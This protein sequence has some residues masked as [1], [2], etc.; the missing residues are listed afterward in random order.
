MSDCLFCKIADG[1]IKTELLAQDEHAVAFRDIRPQAPTHLLVIPRR[2]IASLN[3][4]TEAD[5]ALIG[6]LHLV[7]QRLAADLGAE[8]AGDGVQAQVRVPRVEGPHP[9]RAAQLLPVRR[10]RGHHVVRTE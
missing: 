10:D 8:L 5:E 4:L 7:A 6:H 2:H 3:E 1:T 9:R